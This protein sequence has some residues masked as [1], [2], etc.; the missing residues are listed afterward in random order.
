M[1]PDSS[2][3]TLT[4]PECNTMRSSSSCTAVGAVATAPSASARSND[5]TGIVPALTRNVASPQLSMRTVSP[6]RV[7][8]T[9][10]RVISNK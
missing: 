3:E 1:R 6:G 9:P 7:S 2:K 8:T 5:V 4:S 10:V